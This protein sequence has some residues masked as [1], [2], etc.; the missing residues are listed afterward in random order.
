MILI[1]TS[2]LVH[3]LRSK[4]DREVKERVRSILR[5]GDVAICPMIE[6]ELAMGVASAKDRK[7]VAEL[8]ALLVHLPINEPVWAEAGRLAGA[9]RQ[10]GTP[11]PASDLVIA[12]CA[13]VHGAKIEAADKHFEILG[14]L[15]QSHSDRPK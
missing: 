6:V 5:G 1:D 7:E 4:G 12:A 3:F 15:V 2:S 13:S 9:C 8:C 11:V 10:Q 14:M